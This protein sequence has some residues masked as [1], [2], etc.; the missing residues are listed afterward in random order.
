MVGTRAGM[1]A[2]QGEAIASLRR[3]R[4]VQTSEETLMMPLFRPVLRLA[5]VLGLGALLS[6]CYYHAPG[7]YYAPKSYYGYGGHGHGQKLHRGHGH[8]HKY[9]RYRPYRHRYRGY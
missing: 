2:Y 5:A 6:A 9:G 3:R 8:G 1:G 7:V 4:R